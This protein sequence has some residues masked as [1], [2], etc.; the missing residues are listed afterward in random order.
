MPFSHF[1]DT[2]NVH[3]RQERVHLGDPQP[4]G[5]I[6]R[7]Q[8][9]RYSVGADVCLPVAIPHQIAQTI[10]L[11][12]RCLSPTRAINLYRTWETEHAAVVMAKPPLHKDMLINGCKPM[13]ENGQ[14]TIS[15]SD[16]HLSQY[17]SHSFTPQASQKLHSD[18]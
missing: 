14:T 18:L 7:P 13:K 10:T 6:F 12:E 2:N 8:Q 11:I 5:S 16:A 9:S 1:T 15:N 4:T 3:E 17:F